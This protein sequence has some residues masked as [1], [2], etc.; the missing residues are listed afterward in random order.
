AILPLVNADPGTEYLSDGITESIINTLSQLPQLKVMARSTVFR[1][2]GL[3]VDPQEVG[4]R[5]GVRAV[6]TGRVLHRGDTLNI[7]TELVDVSDGSQRWGEQYNRQL[8]DVFAIEGEISREISE[9][10]RL[11][12]T[13]EEQ[14]RLAKRH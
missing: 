9:K 1:Y 13:G 11:K 12:L 2:K 6:L 14:G 8:S 3:E 4:S 7:Q 10:L 5:L